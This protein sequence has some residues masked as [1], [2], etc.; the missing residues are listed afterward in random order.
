MVTYDFRPEVIG[1]PDEIW[2]FTG[3]DN[4]EADAPT[5][6]EGP[7][8]HFRAR[9]SDC[10]RAGGKSEQTAK[11]V[12]MIA[13]IRLADESQP[14]TL[15]FTT[16]QI[17]SGVAELAAAAGII[18]RS[19]DQLAVFLADGGAGIVQTDAGPTFNQNAFT[20]WL[21]RTEE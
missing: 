2:D 16:G 7:A 20:G 8:L 17:T 14:I 21:N 6:P 4:P 5:L 9:I 10:L 3:A 18:A 11:G 12:L 19:G 15:L 1:D 13:S